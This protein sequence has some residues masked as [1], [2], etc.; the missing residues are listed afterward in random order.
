MKLLWKIGK[1]V[2]IERIYLVI[3]W[4]SV[5]FEEVSNFDMNRVEK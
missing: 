2:D 5:I 3:E 1:H 4:G